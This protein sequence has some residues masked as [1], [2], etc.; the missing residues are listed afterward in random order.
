[1]M[2]R[3]L[4]GVCELDHVS[5]VVG[6]SQE[7]NTSRQFIARKSS[8]DDDRRNEDQEGIQMRRAFVIHIRWVQPITEERRLVL[9]SLMYDRVQ[10]VVSH[11]L[12]E[13]GH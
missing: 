8:R 2:G 13:I 12:Q 4:I 11:D 10:P 3:L 9:Y 6:S 1:M 7:N 5:I